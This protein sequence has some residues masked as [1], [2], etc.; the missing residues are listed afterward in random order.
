MIFD[1]RS[2][3]AI[4]HAQKQART[5]RANERSS[6]GYFTG[7]FGYLLVGPSRWCEMGYLMARHWSQFRSC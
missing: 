5:G 6:L 7:V 3:V 1:V 4:I 2:S